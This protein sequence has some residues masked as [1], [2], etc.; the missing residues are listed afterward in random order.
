[1]ATTTQ[2]SLFPTAD[3]VEVV[4]QEA[5]TKLPITNPNEL[6]ALLELHRNTIINTMRSTHG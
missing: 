2:K 4:V 3:S 6:I 5:L 1:M